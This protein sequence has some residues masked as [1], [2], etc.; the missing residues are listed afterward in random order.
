MRELFATAPTKISPDFAV[1]TSEREVRDF[2][3][4]HTFPLIIK[5]A[6]LSK[7]LLV[8]KSSSLEELLMN[9]QKNC[10]AD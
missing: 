2:A 3:A 1:I 5:P 7:S 10:S 9:Y 6:N 8:T 4:Q